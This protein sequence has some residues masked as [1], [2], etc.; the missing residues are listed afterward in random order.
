M[1]GKTVG[2]DPRRRA[3]ASEHLQFLLGRQL[4]VLQTR[5]PGVRL[6][7]DPEDLKRFRIATRRARA[8]I[9]ATHRLLDGRLAELE[10]ELRWLG[11]VL[12]PARDLDVL[13][14]RLHSL[15]GEL[16]D[17]AAPIVALIE[18]ERND[19]RQTMLA[20]LESPRYNELLARF[21]F[22]LGRL[23]T[24]RS[25]IGLRKLAATETKRLRKAYDSLGAAPRDDDLHALRIKVKRARYST[26][27][28][29]RKRREDMLRALKG[30]Q[31]VIGEHQDSIVAEQRLRS[32]AER[33]GLAVERI[34][35]IEQARRR[36][37]RA[38]LAG[39]W[40]RVRREL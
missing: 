37:A 14:E 27:L 32:L 17:G 18:Q 11:G 2:D 29:A 25:H 40:R 35:E 28:A 9:R 21:A 7:T 33:A 26:E 16:G 34:I 12:G 10:A 20:A 3:P 13:L 1:V 24:S 19:A 23:E 39:A 8:L 4:L 6:G 30:L 15:E 22:D 38:E 31:D 36:Q 5:D